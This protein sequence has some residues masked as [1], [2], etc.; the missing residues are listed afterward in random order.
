MNKTL[1]GKK[2]YLFLIND[3]SKELDIH[4]NNL[5]VVTDQSLQRYKFDNF[6][7][8]VIPNKSYIYKEYLPDNYDLKYRPA[9]DIYKKVLK[10]KVIDAYDVLKNEEDTY[11]KTDTHINIKGGYIVYNYFI[12][13][14]NKI[15]NLDIK[16]KQIKI[17]NKKC[18]LS[19]LN[20][21]IGDLLWENNLG[22]QFV[23]DRIDTFYYS[24]DIEYIYT[25]HKIQINGKLR[26]LSKN[27]IDQNEIL[28][29]SIIT[30][31]ILSDYILYKKN[32]CNNNLKVII[33]YDSL[34]SSLLDL[35]L[36]LFEEVYMIKDIYNNVIID[37]IKPDY[38]FEFRVERFLF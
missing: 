6:C 33:F 11:Y 23:E 4:C 37:S 30:W 21:G 15:Y 3:S 31:Y 12:Q 35:Y 17:L 36:E 2:N 9:F 10:N 29:G 38:V 14:L 7:L 26:I 24:D 32:V 27:L 25:K 18:I 20:L 13:E 22:K 5:N 1:I 28:N 16:P 19:E 34:L 8:I